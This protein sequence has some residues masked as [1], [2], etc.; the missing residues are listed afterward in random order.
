MTSTIVDLPSKTRLGVGFETD[1]NRWKDR[2]AWKRTLGAKPVRARLDLLPDGQSRW[3]RL[4]AS[5]VMQAVLL[6][7]F[8]VL[9]IFFPE[10]LQTAIRYQVI[11]LMSPVVEVPV[12]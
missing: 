5:F 3:N 1:R 2:E 12:A 4:G 9:P 11:P 6:S 7:F 8:V 10:R